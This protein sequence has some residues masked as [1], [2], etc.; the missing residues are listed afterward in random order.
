MYK[1]IYKLWPLIE[2]NAK[3][4]IQKLFHRFNSLDFKPMTWFQKDVEMTP[5]FIALDTLL[6]YLY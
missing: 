1:L 5:K 4:P 2:F 6:S 3:D